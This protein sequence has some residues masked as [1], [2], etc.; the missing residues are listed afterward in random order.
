ML[1]IYREEMINPTDDNV[2][3]AEAI[4]GKQRKTRSVQFSS[5][6]AS[7]LVR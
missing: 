2:G 6:S 7:V 3:M 1:F 4:I 5:P